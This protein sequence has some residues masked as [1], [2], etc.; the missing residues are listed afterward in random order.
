MSTHACMISAARSIIQYIGNSHDDIILNPLPLS[1]DYGLYQVI[2]S[3]MFGGTVVLEKSFHF[4]HVFM[5]RIAEEGVTGLPLVPTI[6]AMLLRMETLASY[7][8]HSLRYITSTGAALPPAHI[9]RLRGLFPHARLF[10]MFGL[11][12]CKRV[13]Y[14][15]PDELESRPASV[16]KPMPNCSVSVVDEQGREVAPHQMGQLVVW[17]AN[18]MQGYWNDPELTA[19]TY[20]SGRHPGERL[21][22]TGDYFR[23]DEE[24]FLYFLGR[25]D[26]MIKT[27]GERVSPKEIANAL[28]ALDGVS[29]A[30]ATGVPDALLGQSIH[31]YVVPAAE[32][33][34]TERQVLKYCSQTLEPYMMPQTV[35]FVQ[36]LPKSVNG[37]VQVDPLLEEGS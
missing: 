26:D 25:K 10:S 13:S 2:M 29:E 30:V 35:H 23:R 28:C 21:L 22:Y 20:R 1:F 6:A 12:E 18:V 15:S 3:V 4:P 5:G 8:T 33:E 11:T 34:L 31:V 17:G 32:V 9:L 19:R 37:K 27:R 14:L 16:G 36:S 7:D 24:G